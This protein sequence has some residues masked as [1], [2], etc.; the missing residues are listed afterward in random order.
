MLVISS[1]SGWLLELLTELINWINYKLTISYKV[2]KTEH[3]ILQEHLKSK[4]FST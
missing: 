4:K 3:C 1:R 2:M